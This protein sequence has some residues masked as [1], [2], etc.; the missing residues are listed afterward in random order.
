MNSSFNLIK[1]RYYHIAFAKLFE[2]QNSNVNKIDML[3]VV[4]EP[5]MISE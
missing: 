2:N 1:K 3:F 5:Y 4:I